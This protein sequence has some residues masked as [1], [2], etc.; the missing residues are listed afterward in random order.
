VVRLRGPQ[1]K[2]SPKAP[3]KLTKPAPLRAGHY[4]ASF[5]C[6]EEVLNLWLSKRALPALAE[7][8]ANTF[9]VCR[10]RRVVGYYS[11]ATAS[12]AHSD[13]TSSLRRNT[14][15]PIPAMILARLAVDKTEKGNQ[16][17]RHLLQDALRRTLAAARYVAAR[18][19]LVHALNSDVAAYYR[20]LGFIDLPAKAGQITLHLTLEKILSAVKAQAQA[21]H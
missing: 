15:D 12:I 5:D 16:I 1:K 3:A 2:T 20:K 10:G 21:A 4:L 17:G 11:L 6:G 9:V 19:L 14:P 7:R 13:T 18:T 8:T